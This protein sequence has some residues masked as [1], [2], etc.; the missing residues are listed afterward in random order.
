MVVLKKILLARSIGNWQMFKLF[1]QI[2]W[3]IF[4]FVLAGGF[5]LAALFKLGLPYYESKSPLA[6]NKTVV[7]ERGMGVATIAQKLETEGIIYSALGFKAVLKFADQFVTE[8]M[9]LKAGEYEFQAG[10]TMEQVI[11]QLI[12]GDVVLRQITFPEGRTSYE[13][14]QQ[15]N[16]YEALTRG[17]IITEIPRE[18]SLL[19]DTY[20]YQKENTAG[21]ILAQMTQ[22]MEKALDEAW[23]TRAADVPLK[24]KQE[25]LVLASLIEKETGKAEEREKVAGVFVNR[26]RKGMLLQTDPTVIYALTKGKHK[27]EGLGPLNRRLLRKDLQIESP[28]NTY[29]YAGL[30]PGPICNPGVASLKAAANPGTHDYLYFVADGTGGHFFGK[31]LA[32]HNRNVTTWRRIRR[33]RGF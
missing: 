14:V 25:L 16:E 12:D 22:A 23:E 32:E 29:K 17:S 15:L 5:L 1:K 13:I 28:Y 7:I 8:D 19:P 30:P 6:E 9:S 26:L 11:Q 4:F 2:I 33:E 18:G 31:N 21:D 10:V 20:R 24:N 27:R 3:N